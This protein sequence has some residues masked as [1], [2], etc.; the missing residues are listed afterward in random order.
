MTDTHRS[1]S[2]LLSSPGR[3]DVRVDWL[4]GG[5]EMALVIKA[6][7]WSKTPLG[8]IESWPQSLRTTVSLAQASNSP[9]SLVWGPGHVQIYNDGYWPICGA[10]HPIAM[11]QD[12]RE[13]WASAFPVIG[14]AYASAW[15]GKSAY[16][17]NMR[18]F[19]DRY[20]FLE[21]TCFTFSF[22]PITDESGAVG[23]L[24]HPVTEVTSQ[25]LSER[26]TKTLRD[27][28]SRVG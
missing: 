3:S 2:E 26:R 24:F 21:E 14:E 17:E 10:K 23:G 7:D 15:S 1:D 11:G 12:F 27:L 16:L 13:C 20:G 6:M 25:M 22:S 9:I 5:G 8:P 4:V 18:M 28:A 19:L